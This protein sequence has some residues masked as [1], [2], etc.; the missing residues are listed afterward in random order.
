MMAGTTLANFVTQMPVQGSC[1]PRAVANTKVYPYSGRSSRVRIGGN[2]EVTAGTA[3]DANGVFHDVMLK[4]A[5]KEGALCEIKQQALRNE[6]LKLLTLPPHENVVRILG[7]SIGKEGQEYLVTEMM[8]S[9]LNDAIWGDPEGKGAPKPLTQGDV[10]RIVLGVVEG[11]LHIH[12]HQMIHNDLKPGNILLDQ[13]MH[14]KICDFGSCYYLKPWSTQ[15]GTTPAYLAPEC[16][17]C[18]YDDRDAR[19][20]VYSLGLVMLE[21][22]Q[23]PGE[24]DYGGNLGGDVVYVETCPVPIRKMCQ[25]QLR[26]LIQECLDVDPQHRPT[27]HHIKGQLKV[28]MDE[29]LEKGEF[30]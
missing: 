20:E 28:M 23:A 12:N 4:E 29:S 13:Y 30:T 24:V 7:F 14:P 19:A 10:L 16:R 27:L 3:M 22:V 1:G 5:P 9:S 2:G 8:W 15:A 26:S 25:P 17:M 18:C 6:I 21:C 11:L